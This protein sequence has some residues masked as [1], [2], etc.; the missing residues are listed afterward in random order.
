MKLWPYLL[1][2]TLTTP[3]FAVQKCMV[4]GK[5]QYKNG[6]CPPGTRKPINGGTL[7]ELNL[8]EVRKK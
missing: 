8:S 1:L 3:A 7:S 6:P 2:L 5:T 4:D